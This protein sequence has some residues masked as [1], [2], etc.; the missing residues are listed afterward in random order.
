ML[1]KQFA[2]PQK[3]LH[4]SMAALIIAML[5]I[6]VGMISTLAPKYL[7]LIRIH[8]SLGIVI[9]ALALVRIA[10]RRYYGAPPLPADLPSPMRFAATSSQ[11]LFY[12]LMVG[13]PLIGWGMLSAGSHPVLLFGSVT[14]PAILPVD[15]NVYSLLRHAHDLLGL[16]FFA[17]I[18]MHI[19]ALLF[20]KLVRKDG[21]FDTMAPHS[22]SRPQDAAQNVGDDT[23][24][25][26]SFGR[27]THE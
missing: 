5:F 3:F 21:V 6:G 2:T 15:P 17:F 19:A 24:Y 27:S 9:L 11:Y 22:S 20:H 1:R 25:G 14:L 7:I 10:A 4:W 13:M 23:T 12:A 8:K 26:R 18:L 16:T